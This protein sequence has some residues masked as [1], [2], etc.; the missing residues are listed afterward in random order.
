[1]KGRKEGR[2]EGKY[3]CWV[4]QQSLHGGL[5][6]FNFFRESH[7]TKEGIYGIGAFDGKN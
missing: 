4:A 5:T 7:T 3:T 6:G 2:K 1:M